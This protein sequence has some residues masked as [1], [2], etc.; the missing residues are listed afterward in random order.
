[1]CLREM[2]LFAVQ[3]ANESSQTDIMDKGGN[4]MSG[5]IV[6][7]NLPEIEDAGLVPSRLEIGN[8]SIHKSLS[9]HSTWRAAASIQPRSSTQ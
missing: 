7:Y 5:S 1:M 6:T 9:L 8:I 4:H 2:R 3:R